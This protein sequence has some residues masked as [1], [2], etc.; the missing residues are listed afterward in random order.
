LGFQSG[1]KKIMKI[2]IDLKIFIFIIIFILTRQIQIYG[3]L[4]LF[5]FIHEL[6]HILA[7]IILGLKP[8]NLSIMPY[9]L[10]VAFETKCEDYNKK[11]K[12]GNMLAIKK[13]IIASAGPITNLII[14]IIF[15]IFNI[16]FLGIQRE[17]IVYSNILIGIFN[18]IPIYPL[19][20]GRIIKNILHIKFGLKDS[21]KY[22]NQIS[23]ITIC[24][25]T[26]VSSIVILYVKNI[27]ILIILAYLWYLV[28]HWGRFLLGKVSLLEI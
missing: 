9:G 15:I 20:G 14:T 2:K 16:N 26:A 7:G 19:D 18:L 28:L 23:K 12:N 24:I 21:Y 4:M 8:T 27:A 3:I 5:A 1:R 6:G 17:L 13:I 11:V 10:S 22:T 25:I